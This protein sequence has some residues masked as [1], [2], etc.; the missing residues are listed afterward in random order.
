[1]ATVYLAR[2]LKH[3]RPV[4]IKVLRPDLAAAIGAERFLHEIRLT[5]NLQH[6]NI[7]PLFDSG[8]ADGRLFYVMPYV[9]GETLRQR[10]SRGHQFA[11]ADAI[12]LIADV[13]DALAY[14]HA[15]GVVHRDIKPENILLHQGRVLVADFGIASASESDSARLTRAGMVIGTPGYMS[16]EQA[17]GS[18]VD[19]RSDQYSLACM[20]SEMLTA[21]GGAL[22]PSAETVLAGSGER[23]GPTPARADLPPNVRDAIR[24]A[25]SRE[26]DARFPR[27]AAFVAALRSPLASADEKSIAVLAFANMSADPDNEYFADGIAEEIINA[28]TQLSDLRVVARTSAFSFKGTSDDVRTVGERLQVRHVL[29]GSV[30]KS[31]NR[32]RITAQLVSVTDGYRL[33]SEKYDREM[34]DVF[35]I[36]DEIATTIAAKLQITLAGVPGRQLVTPSTDN[37]EAYELYLKGRALMHRRGSRIVEGMECFRRAIA[38]DAD[39][40]PALAGLA[41]ALV[42]SSLWGFT[43]PKDVGGPALGAATR[44]I[45]AAPELAEAHAAVALAA[46]AVEFDAVKAGREWDRAIALSPGDDDIRAARALFHFCYV[47]GRFE[48]SEAELRLALTNDPLNQTIHAQLGLVLAFA[49]RPEEAIAQ[50]NRAIAL[51]PGVL[52]GR[53]V[54]ILALVVSG[55]FED[56]IATGVE[57]MRTFGRNAWVMLG[58]AKAYAALGRLDEATALFDELLARSRTEHV[59]PGV[60]ALIAMDLGRRDDA[61]RRW[62]E[63]AADRD[64]FMVAMLLHAPIADAM[65][66]EPEHAALVRRLGWDSPLPPADD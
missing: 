8:S 15:Q 56:V 3:D 5:A 44:A 16:P 7:L 51:D 37:L 13:A 22:G 12:R 20:L 38:L 59:Q 29:E 46:V 19:G 35:A 42:L 31:G 40:A 57:I 60:L 50:A 10:L 9:D 11:V 54:L 41:Q 30:R 47:C 58:M 17:S 25:T 43:N 21:T 36:Q 52:F 26:P 18:P 23:E 33:W 2:D 61:M 63:A 64:M 53:W 65:R 6:P 55:A 1:M 14:A 27:V 24:R 66:R 45:S 49:R 62:A 4:A 32:L 34:D 39:Y 28:L 48:R